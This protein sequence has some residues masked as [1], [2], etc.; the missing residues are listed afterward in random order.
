V[1]TGGAVPA[2]GSGPRLVP[3]TGARAAGI[4]VTELR[5]Q[6]SPPRGRA[7]TV[8]GRPGA[9]RTR[10]RS[11]AATMAGGLRRRLPGRPRGARSG[12]SL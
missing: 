5:P 7:C 4:K 3:P 10:G 9:C 6:R 11:S 12:R 1:S 8:R 2:T